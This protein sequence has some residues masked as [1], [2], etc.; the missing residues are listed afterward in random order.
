MS[1]A[2]WAITIAVIVGLLVLD[3]VVAARRPH[4]VGI[5]EATF[6]SVF[7]VGL[8]LL[9]GA[10]L[11]VA[12]EPGQ[13]T[14]Y[15]AG[16]VV[17]KS[18]SVDNLFVF[19]I[20]MTR[21]AVPDEFQQKVLL[22][23]IAVALGMRAVFIAIGSAV[24]SAFSW[25]FVVFGLFLVYTA[26]QLARHRNEDPDVEDSAVLR[27]ARKRLPFTDRFDGSRLLT[28]ENGKRVATPLFLVFLAIGSTDLLFALDSIPA[29]FGVT[30]DAY[31]VFAANAFAL[32]GLRALYF[33]IQ[34]LLA[35][36]VYL[37]L[38]LA[39]I[40]AFIGV[41]LILLFLHEDVSTSFPE[42]P[43]V[44]SLVVIF[45]ILAVTTV[46]SL[47]RTRTHPEEQAH[48]GALRGHPPVRDEATTTAQ[49]RA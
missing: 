10:L 46:A 29:V 33:L 22:F 21:F 3:F 19:V 43:T 25:T 40:L 27:F 18:L 5:R 42:I 35:R 16:W 23:G 13:G 15:F 48:A 49:T 14:E 12:G 26:V 1:V 34:G 7:Y 6:W 30:Q 11:V 17:E 32:L 2:V 41:K 44:L 20:I 28:R 45:G 31:I 4:H 36:L 39:V 47:L 37:S 38:G 24:I 8:A 9:F